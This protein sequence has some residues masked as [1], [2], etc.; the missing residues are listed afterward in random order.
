MVVAVSERLVLRHPKTSDLQ[1]LVAT[2]T[3]PEVARRMGDFGPR[4]QRAVQ[5][6]LSHEARVPE[7]QAGDRPGAV[8]FTIVRRTDDAVL[9][10]LGMGVSSDGLAAWSF[11]YALQPEARGR[12][13]AGEALAASIESASK[14]FAVASFWGECDADNLAS[15]RTMVAAGLSEVAPSADGSRRFVINL[16]C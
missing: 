9:G 15:V 11:G 16:A 8:Q 13:Y 4:D 6:W 2:W 1:G 3:D 10:W 14:L 7:P 12:R 5:A